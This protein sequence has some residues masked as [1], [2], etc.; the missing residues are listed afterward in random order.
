M[1][2]EDR[3]LMADEGEIGKE[4]DEK[5]RELKPGRDLTIVAAGRCVKVVLA[6]VAELEQDGIK[7]AVQV[8]SLGHIK[9][10][11]RATV[12]DAARRTRRVLVVQDEPPFG[13]YGP[14]VQSALDELPP[15][16]LL[17]SP[18]L[19]SRADTF[20]PFLREEDHLPTVR[21]VRDA[22]LALLK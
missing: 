4:L 7:G 14:M 8:L 13:G 17:R 16:A 22:A 11:D 12:L 3:S 2:L 19:L 10:F 6:A 1:F 9:P 20:L 21:Q 15:D 5:A 18:K